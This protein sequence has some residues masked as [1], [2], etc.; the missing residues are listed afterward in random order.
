MS[1]NI[2]YHNKAIM[3]VIMAIIT[4][5]QSHCCV[6]FKIPKKK[7]RFCVGNLSWGKWTPLELI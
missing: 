2:Y 5:H 7:R 4:I 1:Y 3:L 6:S